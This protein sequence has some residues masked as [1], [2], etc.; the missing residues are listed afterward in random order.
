MTDTAPR[1]G[2]AAR[3][4]VGGELIEWLDVPKRAVA[5]GKDPQPATMAGYVDTTEDS[6]GVHTNSG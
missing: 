2:M 4:T 1:P 6:G 5:L 3:R